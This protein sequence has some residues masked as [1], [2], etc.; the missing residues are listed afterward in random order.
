MKV[1][2][3]DELIRRL[4]ERVRRS[5]AIEADA[6]CV[7]S[8]DAGEILPHPPP[9]LPAPVALLEDVEGTLG[10]R[11]P[12]LVRR[13]YTEVADGEY[14]P[15][16]GILRLRSPE[17]TDI[18]NPWDE[19]MSVEAWAQVYRELP[20][21]EPLP[22]DWPQPLPPPSSSAKPAATLRTGWTALPKLPASSGMTTTSPSRPRPIRW[23]SG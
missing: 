2:S 11:L 4:Q 13:L 3:V 18:W 20:E 12:T 10:F 15:S 6:K 7:R 17:G 14:G 9:R 23:S 21:R 1:V 22:D 16:C 5:P 8:N 19:A